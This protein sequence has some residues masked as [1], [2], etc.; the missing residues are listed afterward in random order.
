V[1]GEKAKKKMGGSCEGNGRGGEPARKGGR[2][3]EL[4]TLTVGK[5]K[6]KKN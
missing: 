1:K 4:L 6:K 3:V 2:G 5:G